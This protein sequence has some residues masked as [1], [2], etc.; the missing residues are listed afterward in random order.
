MTRKHGPTL[1]AQ[2]LGELLKESRLQAAKTLR[3]AADYLTLDPATVSRYESGTIPAKPQ[4]VVALMTL[5]GVDDD[6][7]RQ[8]LEQLSRESWRK[9]WWDGYQGELSGRFI[10][11]AWLEDRAVAI[12][13]FDALTLPGLVQTPDFARAVIRSHAPD[14]DDPNIERGVQFRMERQR[15]LDRENPP[16]ISIIMDEALLHRPIGGVR[17]MRS[18]LQHL[19]DLVDKGTVE[20]RVLPFA[21]GAHC[22]HRGG[23][24]VFTLPEPFPEIGYAESTTGTTYVE[25]D[26][27]DRLV[28]AYAQLSDAALSPDKSAARLARAAKEMT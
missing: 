26:A 7:R 13:S 1:R 17:A 3:D 19:N 24:R 11:Y 2:W 5:Y 9:G 18:Q 16:A 25:A 22:G 21:A 10:D 28:W 12:R 23:F 8:W 15:I 4:D 14:K 20:L 6:A 27:A